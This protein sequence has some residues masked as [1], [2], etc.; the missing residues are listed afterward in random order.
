MGVYMVHCE[1]ILTVLLLGSTALL[2]QSFSPRSAVSM[3]NG[4]KITFAPVQAGIEIFVPSGRRIFGKATVVVGDATH[5]FSTSV[6]LKPGVTL[7]ERTR[8]RDDE[9]NPITKG[10]A[11]TSATIYFGD[12]VSSGHTVV[13]CGMNFPSLRCLAR[14]PSGVEA[15]VPTGSPPCRVLI[16][17]NSLFESTTDL[18]AGV[19]E[20]R[21]LS[22]RDKLGVPIPDN[23]TFSAA[24][25]TYLPNGPTYPVLWEKTARK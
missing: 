16:R 22:F 13:W 14:T 11:L 18:V 12:D 17:V 2:A 1:L 3:P 8:F 5:C 21:R 15:F 19:T 10:I 9:A 23:T 4:E 20:I 6:D 25:V 7:L 24:T